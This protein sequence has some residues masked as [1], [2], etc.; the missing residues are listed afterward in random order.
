MTKF[1]DFTDAVLNDAKHL[2]KD[3]F[4]GFEDQAAE[5]AEGF[6]NKTQADVKRW[7]RLLA[8]GKLTEQD[9]GDLLAAK[10]ALAEMHA[11]TL[12][13]IALTKIERFRSGLIDSV[14]DRAFAILL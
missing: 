9:F 2:A 5:I 13:G 7:S 8:E 14:I 10:K 12:A 1:S 6:L 11:L 4:D 3:I